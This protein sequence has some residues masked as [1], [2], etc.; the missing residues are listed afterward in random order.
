MCW[1]EYDLMGWLIARYVNSFIV[2]LILSDLNDNAEF[3]WGCWVIWSWM[4]WMRDNFLCKRKWKCFLIL[5]SFIITV[6][7]I[8]VVLNSKLIKFSLIKKIDDKPKTYLQQIMS[9]INNI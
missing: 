2:A 4:I 3:E 1:L 8:S 9:K 5:F 7:N 6:N